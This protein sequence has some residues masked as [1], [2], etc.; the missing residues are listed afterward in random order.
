MTKNLNKELAAYTIVDLRRREIELSP[1]R[2]LVIEPNSDD[3]IS[4]GYEPDYRGISVEVFDCQQQNSTN[5][6]DALA[7]IADRTGAEL[8][9]LALKPILGFRGTSLEAYEVVDDRI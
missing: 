7:W 4:A 6:E 5:P 2:P 9:W 1:G 8:E 3:M